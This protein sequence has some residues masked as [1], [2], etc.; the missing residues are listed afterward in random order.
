MKNRITKILGSE[1]PLLLGPMRR[2]TMGEMAAAVSNSGGFGQVAASGATSDQLR[3]EIK[4]ARK[5]TNRPIGV[6]I[7]IYRANAMEALEIAIEMGI[8]TITTSAGNPAKMMD[9]IK[10]AGL[11]VLHKVSTVEMGLK[12]QAAGVD[13][14]I[15]TGYEAGG[16]IGRE[17]MTT[18][19]LVPQLVDALDIPVVAAGGIGDGRC[20]LAA[21]CLGAE[22]VEV[23]TRFIATQEWPVPDFYKQA[24]L[25]G[26]STVVPEKK[27]MPFRILRNKRAE[28]MMSNVKEAEAAESESSDMFQGGAD[29]SILGAGQVVGLIREI[30]EVSRV[31]PDMLQ[32]A[33]FLSAKLTEFFKEE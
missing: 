22:G 13:G 6:N 8:Q 15:A 23:G 24:V 20:L 30:K 12:A 5:L 27:R 3:A 7:P 4:K 29:S 26:N 16:H 14:V 28:A 18:F 17:D 1:Y 2:I 19:C 33:R 25:I 11:R 32:E 21:F 9:K 10:G 31:F